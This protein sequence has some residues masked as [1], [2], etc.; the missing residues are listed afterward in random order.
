MNRPGAA[1]LISVAFTAA[2][3]TP[4]GEPD[5]SGVWQAYA[6]IAAPGAG[7]SGALATATTCWS[8]RSP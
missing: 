4:A 2:C 3:T 6:S 8:S 7:Q 1:L 5:I